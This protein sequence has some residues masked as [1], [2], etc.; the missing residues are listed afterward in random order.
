MFE[1]LLLVGILARIR[2]NSAV[3]A[4][5]I[6]LAMTIS[7]D[8]WLFACVRTLRDRV[9]R[10]EKQLECAT[11]L[12]MKPQVP[13]RISLCELVSEPSLLL[14]PCREL[15]NVATNVPGMEEGGPRM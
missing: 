5:F 6:V 9:G 13:V 3:L 8:M 10:L 11:A 2:V 15:S 14:A 4:V 7:A 12:S 1:Y